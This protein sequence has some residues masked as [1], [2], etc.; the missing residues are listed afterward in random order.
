MVGKRVQFD[1]ILLFLIGCLT[2]GTPA[3]A[4]PKEI[5]DFCFRQ[6]EQV[7]PPLS[8]SRGDRE[9]FM[10]ACIADRVAAPPARRPYKKPR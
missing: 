9:A 2:F 6:I 5:E 7:R 1:Q 3:L 4:A 10:A 8:S